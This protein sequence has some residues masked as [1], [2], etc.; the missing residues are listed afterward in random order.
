MAKPIAVIEKGPTERLV[1]EVKEYKGRRYIDLRTYFLNEE[2]EMF[3]TK[4]GVTLNDETVI[5]VIEAL[6]KAAKKMEALEE[7]KYDKKPKG[8]KAQKEA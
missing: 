1:V 7:A 6:T 5:E 2:K 4:K 8:K 3:P